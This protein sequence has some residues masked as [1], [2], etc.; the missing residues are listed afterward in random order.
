MELCKHREI[1]SC[2]NSCHSNV[3]RS[4]YG[5]Y[6]DFDFK[7]FASVIL[8]NSTTTTEGQGVT[9]TVF[10][11]NYNIHYKY[12]NVLETKQFSLDVTAIKYWSLRLEHRQLHSDL[13]LL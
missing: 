13:H 12:V 8:F 3:S 4:E 5:L 9:I 1:L 10:I 11:I 7:G 2:D 6:S